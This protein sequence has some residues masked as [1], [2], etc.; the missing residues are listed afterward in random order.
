[1]KL[2]RSR[3]WHGLALSLFLLLAACKPP[4]PPQ[5]PGSPIV[6]PPDQQQMRFA[7]ALFSIYYR[8]RLDTGRVHAEQ[9]ILQLA[10]A[11][12]ILRN[13][14][15]R[16]GDLWRVL[17]LIQLAANGIDKPAYR[18]AI[19]TIAHDE[20]AQKKLRNLLNEHP[21][22]E[23][24]LRE[25]ILYKYLLGPTTFLHLTS[26][27][28]PNCKSTYPTAKAD[29]KAALVTLD[30]TVWVDKAPADVGQVMDPQSWDNKCG[31][32][33]YQAAHLTDL[34]NGQFETDKDFNATL[35]K[36]ETVA[37]TWGPRYLFE[38]F[39]SPTGGGGF[40]KTILS[41]ETSRKS[42]DSE[43][44]V[45]FYDLEAS[46][47][48]ELP[49]D[50]PTTGGLITDKGYLAAVKGTAPWTLLSGQKIVHFDAQKFPSHTADQIGDAA[51]TEL[52]MMGNGL[53]YWVCC[54]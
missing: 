51:A 21:G 15:E 36:P 32:L 50:P 23:L 5:V 30:M 31:A 26:S 45:K 33:F 48:S 11:A 8:V 7:K 52:E 54:P 28:V 19:N 17:A 3:G 12:L 43:Y 47:R 22:A 40:F 49:P 38:Y 41:V 29:H 13:G 24:L 20:N 35:G 34:K 9:S 2:A 6:T 44:T 10:D 25:A 27:G 42:D 18:N 39:N 14:A 37:T 16:F 1:M 53:A 4:A 46:L